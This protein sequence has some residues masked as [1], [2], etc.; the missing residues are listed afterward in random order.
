[1]NIDDVAVKLRKHLVGKVVK[2]VYV[3]E[4]N[5][6]GTSGRVVI[7][8]ASSIGEFVDTHL[9]VCSVEGVVTSNENL[10]WL[11]LDL[12]TMSKRDGCHHH[13]MNLERFGKI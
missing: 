12:I 6:V 4:P 8:F 13:T 3:Q 7:K 5:E 9:E 11:F 2:D 1:M 10:D